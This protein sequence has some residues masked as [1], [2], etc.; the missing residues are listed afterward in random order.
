MVIKRLLAGVLTLIVIVLLAACSGNIENVQE[1]I[2]ETALRATE[3]K[4]NNLDTPL[5]IDTTPLFRWTNRSS[6]TGR[7]QTA[8]QIIVAST[9]ELAT[10]HVGDLWDSGKVECGDNFDIHYEGTPLESCADYY[11]SVCLWDETDSVSDWSPVARFGTGMLDQSD[12]IAKWIGGN[13]QPKGRA[14]APA[15]MLRKSFELTDGIKKAKVYVCGLGLFELKVNGELPDDSVLKPAHTQ[16]EDTINYNVYDVTQLLTEGKNAV[17]V[18]LGNGFYNLTDDISI[19]FYYGVWRDNPKLLLELHVEYENGE[20]EIV[21]S[22]ET[23]RCYD[24][25][26]IRVNNIYRGEQYDA[27][28]EVD[29][30]TDADFDDSNWSVVRMA[31]APTGKL[32]FENMEPMRRVKA[33]TPTVTKVNSNTW[34]VYTGEFCTG[35]AKIAFNTTKNSMIKIRYYQR[36]NEIT[37]GLYV[38]QD[39]EML[40]LQ[41]YLYRAKVS[42]VKPTSR[43]S[44]MPAMK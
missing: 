17:T 42:P 35:W 5:G 23:W 30:W 12:W 18:E 36:E 34:R 21:V 19:D 13:Q 25:G 26:P 11:W 39:S 41:S 29:G 31:D 44:A 28:M 9:P 4:V 7:L 32:R 14:T 27:T 8:Y 33:I 16:Y 1:V 43:N 15:P 6:T 20:K 24:N 37:S 3:L 2:D 40:D 22:D 38:Q 10:A